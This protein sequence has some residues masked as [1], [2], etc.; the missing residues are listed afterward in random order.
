MPRLP[1]AGEPA[2]RQYNEVRYAHVPIAAGEQQVL[3]ADPWSFLHAFLLKKI[4]KSRGENKQSAQRALYFANL[5]ENFYK[6]SEHIELPAK[7]TLVYYGMLNL[8]KSFLSVN[9]V[10]LESKVEH[11]GLTL[12]LGSDRTVQIQGRSREA[13]NI[14][15]EFAKLLGKPVSTKIDI[16][17]QNV[18]TQIPELHGICVTL[19]YLNK[20]K[21]LPVEICFLVNSSYDH[22]FTEVRFKKSHEAKIDTSKFLKGSREKYFREAPSSDGLIC[23]R[24]K[25]RKSLTKDNYDR[26]YKNI[27]KEYDSFDIVSLLTRTGYRYYCDLSPGD[28]HHLCYSLIALYYLGTA[29]RYRP[30]EVDAL[31]NGELRPLVS[32]AAVLC[33]RQ[34]LYQLICRI[35]GKIC[36]IPLSL[37]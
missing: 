18:F 23:Y 30:S 26:I 19:Q 17:L 24:S 36:I 33:P 10:P 5:A 31:L 34:F 11:H 14:F 6:A 3:T 13:V 9:G 22:L 25:R 4:E 2:K 32:E 7:G 27:L 12:P 16:K 28:Y 29:A 20:R 8:V 21:F 35:T 15:A 37:I 1:E